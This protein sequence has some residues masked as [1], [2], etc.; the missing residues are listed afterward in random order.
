MIVKPKGVTVNIDEMYFC[1][2]RKYISCPTRCTP[3][4]YKS[5]FRD[6]QRLVKECSRSNWKLFANYFDVLREQINELQ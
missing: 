1:G 3:V 4:P 5:Y 6:K 2:A